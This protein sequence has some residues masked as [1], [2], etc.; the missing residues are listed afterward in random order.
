MFVTSESETVLSNITAKKKRPEDDFEITL[1]CRAWYYDW[2]PMDIKSVQLE[3]M[4]S[5]TPVFFIKS[6][7]FLMFFF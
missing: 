1:S 6:V 4:R 3:N 2:Y 7:S 5:N